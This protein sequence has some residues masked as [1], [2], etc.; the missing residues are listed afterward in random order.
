MPCQSTSFSVLGPVLLLVAF[1]IDHPDAR[2]SHVACKAQA[3]VQAP[4]NSRPL[5]LPSLPSP[6]QLQPTTTNMIYDL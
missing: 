3:Q 2:V 6:A 1:A 5:P 4:V